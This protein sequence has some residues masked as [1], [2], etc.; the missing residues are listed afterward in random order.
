MGYTHYFKEL[1]RELHE[2]EL[3]II[4]KIIKESGVLIRGG[5][6]DSDSTPSVLKYMIRL[7]G[8]EVDDQGH[9]TFQIGA[10]DTKF[11]FCKTARK[12]YDVVVV[13]ICIYLKSLGIFSW[14]SDGGPE[15]HKEGQELLLKCCP[16][17][18]VKKGAARTDDDED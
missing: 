18:D 6:G 5:S 13:A 8:D 10:G 14:S 17:A 3:N 15:D 7:N 11:N 1:K 12:P 4:N 9:E 16:D 2:E